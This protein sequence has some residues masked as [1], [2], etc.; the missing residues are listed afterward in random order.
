MQVLTTMAG[1]NID[2]TFARNIDEDHSPIV[3]YITYCSLISVS[4]DV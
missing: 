4:E 3:C 2:L 1:W